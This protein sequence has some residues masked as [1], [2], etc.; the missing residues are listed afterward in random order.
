[1][2]RTCLIVEDEPAVKMY[3]KIIL[4]MADY[5]IIEAQN[6]VEAFKV[7]LELKGALDVIVTDIQMPGDM[8]GLDL[9]LTVRETFPAISVILI[10]GVFEAE[11]IRKR[12]GYGEFSQKP[13]SLT[14]L[15]TAVVKPHR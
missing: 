2:P 6:G 15:L 9:A 1:M 12:I 5:T 13:F 3:L 7:A 4:Q 8:D 10:S 11:S 14:S